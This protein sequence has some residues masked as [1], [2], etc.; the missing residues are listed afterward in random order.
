M[1]RFIYAV[2]KELMPVIFGFGWL[3]KASKDWVT[4]QAVHADLHGKRRRLPRI[5]M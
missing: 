2:V 1:Y 5:G 4:G 3:F